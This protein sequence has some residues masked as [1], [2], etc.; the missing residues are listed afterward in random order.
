[1]SSQ[2]NSKSLELWSSTLTSHD[3]W[4]QHKFP[5][6]KGKYQSLQ[7][8]TQILNGGQINNGFELKSLMYANEPCHDTFDCN[9]EHRNTCKLN[10]NS[11][12]HRTSD[13]TYAKVDFHGHETIAFNINYGETLGGV[14]PHTVG[15]VSLWHT[16]R[17]KILVK[18]TNGAFQSKPTL[19]R[20]WQYE[21]IQVGDGPVVITTDDHT[22]I[23]SIR[24]TPGKC[25]RCCSNDIDNNWMRCDNGL[26]IPS[27][28]KCD[29]IDNCGDG[30]DEKICNRFE[31]NFTQNQALSF[32]NITILVL[33]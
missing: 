29:G 22:Q 28:Q 10:F 20:Y 24:L 12:L 8:K 14:S 7:I 31:H 32:D 9:F 2:K 19:S 27:V 23:V 25:I 17:G 21:S 33:Y 11:N 30:T 13:E 16:A 1:M 6:P 15:C 4:T 26:C 3:D 5:I 18:G